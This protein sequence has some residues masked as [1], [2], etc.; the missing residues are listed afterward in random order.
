MS[1][2]IITELKNQILRI[3]MNRPRKRN[4]I[5]REMYRLMA[6]AIHNADGDPL[7]RVIILHGQ[8]EFFTAG[9]DLKDFQSPPP[10][11]GSNPVGAFMKAVIDAKKP[12]IAAVSG[13]AVGIGTTMLFHFDLIYAGNNAKFQLPFVNLGLCPEF[14]SGYLLPRLAGYQRAAELF[15]FGDFFSAQ[16]AYKIG[17]V[18]KIFPEEFLL[19]KVMGEARRL[20]NQPPASIRLTKSLMKKHIPVNIDEIVGYEGLEFIRRLK[21]PEAKEAFAAFYER[22]K[23]DF[24]G[25]R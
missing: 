17:L 14:G 23:P 1:E 25:F 6:D 11:D 19:E 8:K 16:D 20:A 21:S 22:R 4:A 15:Y 18:N 7:I 5:S 3:E 2:D 10:S 12:L 24:S 9:N 13:Y